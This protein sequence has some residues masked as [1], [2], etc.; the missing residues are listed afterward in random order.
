MASSLVRSG[1]VRG[2]MTQG[3]GCYM[4]RCANSTLQIAVDNVWKTCPREGGPIE[5]PGFN[6]T[7]SL[8]LFEEFCKSFCWIRRL[9]TG[10]L[11]TQGTWSVRCTMSFVMTRSCRDL[12]SATRTVMGT[13]SASRG[14]AG[15]SWDSTGKTA[16][17]G[18]ALGKKKKGKSAAATAFVQE[19][20]RVNAKLAT[21]ASTAPRPGATSSAASTAECATTAFV[22]SAAPTTQAT[23]ARTAATSSPASPCA[24]TSS[25]ASPKGNTA[26]PASPPFSSNSR[27]PSSCPTTIA[28][29]LAAAPCSASSTTATAPQ[30]LSA[31][32]AG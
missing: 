18:A 17:G 31:S 25:W 13:G 28:S 23:L 2:S 7:C 22:N 3:N 5:F 4:H 11:I 21:R 20:G 12:G 29:S 30:L 9:L 14:S 19:T 10:G 8:D 16:A 15:V 1:F 32:L 6:G 27:P 26:P 24:E